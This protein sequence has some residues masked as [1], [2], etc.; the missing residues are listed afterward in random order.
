MKKLIIVLL[1]FVAML[2]GCSED[3]LL[4]DLAKSADENASQFEMVKEN[5]G[6]AVTKPFKLRGSGTIEFTYPVKCPDLVQLVAKGTGNATHLGKFSVELNICSNF[7]FQ[8]PENPDL[9][10][11]IT[12][13]QIA[14]NGDELYFYA[15]FA[16]GDIDFNQGSTL[17]HYDKGTG[18][19]LDVEGEITLYGVS[20]L[21]KGVYSN[22]G[23][24][25]IKY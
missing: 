18:R 8:P 11:E 20:D 3:T 23:E 12:G 13:T 9:I 24:G 14:A 15:S 10:Y 19:F 2:F 25:W 21:E 16:N 1:A 7:N 22:Y 17:Y 6:K 4:N 5:K